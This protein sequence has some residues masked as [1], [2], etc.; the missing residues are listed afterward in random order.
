M[1]VFKIYNN[2]T[3]YFYPRKARKLKKIIKL[4]LHIKMHRCMYIQTKYDLKRFNI[5]QIK[6]YIQNTTKPT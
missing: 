2:A 3:F 5:L 6:N 1:D 4:Y